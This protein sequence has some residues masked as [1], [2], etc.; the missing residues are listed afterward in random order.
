[1]EPQVEAGG[2]PLLLAPMA[3]VTDLPFR[4]LCRR[5]GATGGLTEMVSAKALTFGD[6]KSRK[7]CE[8]DPAERPCAIQL[9]GH[10][11]E[12]LGQAARLVEAFAPDGIDLNMGCPMPKIVGS[13]DGAALMRDPAAIEA[14]VRRTVAST[15]RPVTVK[16]RAGI[17][18]NPNAVAC[19]LAA[20]RGGAAGLTVHGRMR[21]QFYRPFADWEFIRAVKQAV[22]IPVIANGDIDSPE[23]AAEA[24][25]QTGADG[26]MVGR[27]ARGNPFLF[28]EIAHYLATGRRLPP[29][30]VEQRMAVAR[31]HL[32]HLVAY[33][34]PRIGIL[35]ARGHL[36]WYLKGLRGAAALRERCNRM[37]SLDELEEILALAVSMQGGEEDERSTQ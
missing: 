15:G 9:F 24:L 18:G 16:L 32:R 27:A 13:G 2:L 11:P 21:E 3:G 22:D 30:S 20:Q 35:E 36:G 37:T 10:E 25:A 26:L 14:L 31:E 33:K 19:A 6:Q 1:M 23:A 17:D 29:P 8:I 7:L 4:L 5:F 12:V 28:R 34:G